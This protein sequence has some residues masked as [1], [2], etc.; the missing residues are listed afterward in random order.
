MGALSAIPRR[1]LISSLIGF[2]VTYDLSLSPCET[3]FKYNRYDITST[4]LLWAK[5]YNLQKAINYHFD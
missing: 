2:A 1:F 4:R 5:P 3:C